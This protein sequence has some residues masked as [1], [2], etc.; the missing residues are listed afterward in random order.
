MVTDTAKAEPVFPRRIFVAAGLSAVLAGG[1]AWSGLIGATSRPE[2]QSFQFSRGVSFAAGEEARLR[3]FLSKA[4]L[5][6]RYVVRIL[7]HSGNAGDEAANLQLSQNRADVAQDIALA[8][9]LEAAQLSAIGL[10]GAAPLPKADDETDRAHQS[11]LARV[12]VTLQM[13]R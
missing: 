8:L 4:T 13:R 11:R 2:T 5:D 10:G 9:G 12:E 7:G 1:I 6:D 3:S